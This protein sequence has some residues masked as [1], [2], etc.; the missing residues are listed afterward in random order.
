[1]GD[2]LGI[3]R[4]QATFWF[5]FCVCVFVN[6]IDYYTHTHTYIHT[7]HTRA[8]YYTYL[9]RYITTKHAPVERARPL[10]LFLENDILDAPETLLG[11]D[12]ACCSRATWMHWIS[13]GAWKQRRRA[14]G[15]IGAEK[16]PCPPPGRRKVKFSPMISPW[17]LR[18]SGPVQQTSGPRT[19]PPRPGL[20]ENIPPV[21]IIPVGD[22]CLHACV[23]PMY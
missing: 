4:A 21:R 5:W 17:S 7:S 11:D 20:G 2:R 19:P 12:A 6:V 9:L 18:V 8:A 16:E 3:P 1:M 23:T 10:T 14:G 15:N 13:P 22:V